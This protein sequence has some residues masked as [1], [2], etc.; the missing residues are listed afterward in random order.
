MKWLRRFQAYV[1]YE[2]V[3]N[4]RPLS[5]FMGGPE[6]D[7]FNYDIIDKDFKPLFQYIKDYNYLG[8]KLKPGLLENVDY[9]IISFDLMKFFYEYFSDRFNILKVSNYNIIER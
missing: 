3:I 6:L 4:Q 9:K 1:S 2:E 5:R 8:S 7:Y